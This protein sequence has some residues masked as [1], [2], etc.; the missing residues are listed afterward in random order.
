MITNA[1]LGGVADTV[2]Q[3]IT[4]VKSHSMWKMPV[5][6]DQ[7]TSTKVL[8]Q[9]KGRAPPVEQLAHHK[10]SPVSFNFERVTRFIAFGFLMAPIQ[11]KWF[12]FLARTLPLTLKHSTVPDL[13]RVVL[14]QLMFAPVGL[15]CIFSFMNG[16]EGGSQEALKQKFSD[17]YLTTLKANYLLWPSVQL[18]NFRVIPLQFQT[19]GFA[20]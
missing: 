13:K 3:L 6:D 7:L 17:V 9:D 16:A 10:T 14:D 4:A 20:S 11:L 1:V 12:G 5:N 19:V 15:A 2:A 18:L 8:D